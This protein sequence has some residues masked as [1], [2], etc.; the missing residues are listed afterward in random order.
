MAVVRNYS[1]RK[2]AK[3][4]TVVVYGSGFSLSTKAWMDDTQCSML[5][6]DYCE[7]KF[8]G[9][10]VPGSYTFYVG[11]S[12]ENRVAI[13]AVDVVDDINKLH[14]YRLAVPTVD[15]SCNA[16]MGLFPRGFA[17]YKGNDGNFARLMRGLADVIILFYE[18]VVMYKTQVSPSHT[19]SFGDWET[20]LRLPEDGVESSGIVVK[21]REEVFRKSCR[22]G[23]VTV[24]YFKSLAALFGIESK[25]YEYWENPGR[26][27]EFDFGDDDPNFYWMLEIKAKEEDWKVCTCNDSCNDYLQ[28]WWNVP[29][30][31]MFGLLKPSHTKLLFSY[32]YE[33]EES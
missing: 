24:P 2:I 15:A 5:D 7:A 25:I 6:Y 13:G 3:G 27:A 21:R 8:T 32:V 30:E 12:S 17:W 20:E 28:R 4:G 22:K 14:L 19:D 31:S 10:S 33:M 16:M 1:G 9:V 23:G 18:L 11:D 26:F 29:I